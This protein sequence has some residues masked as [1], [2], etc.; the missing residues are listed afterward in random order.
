MGRYS[1]TDSALFQGASVRVK[2]VPDMEG[3]LMRWLT[4]VMGIDIRGDKFPRGFWE[5]SPS[6]ADATR[7]FHSASM[8]ARAA[9][10]AVQPLDVFEVQL[11]ADIDTVDNQSGDTN[12]KEAGY[13]G[14]NNRRAIPIIVVRY[15]TALPSLGSQKIV[16]SL[17]DFRQLIGFDTTENLVDSFILIFCRR[18]SCPQGG[19]NPNQQSPPIVKILLP[20]LYQ[21]TSPADSP[22]TFVINPAGRL[23][24]PRKA[25]EKPQLE[26]T[27]Y[28]HGERFLV[29]ARWGGHTDRIFGVRSR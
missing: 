2:H 19:A 24:P 22:P 25:H 26:K 1:V 6:A 18:V 17:I 16:K 4:F 7:N 8:S 21:S 12:M 20:L 23:R 29:G 28:A 10:P 9:C 13:R 3:L 14:N 15:A 27:V 5:L 11:P